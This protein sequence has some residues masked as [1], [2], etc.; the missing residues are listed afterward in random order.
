[1]K[2]I[3]TIH[4]GEFLVGDL[5]TRRFGKRLDVWVPA[6]D[7]GVDLLVTD[8][9]R[10]KPPVGLQVKFSRSYK[11]LPELAGHVRATSWFRLDP[12]KIKTSQADVWVFVI[13]T[14]KHEQHF[15]LIPTR[16]LAKRIPKG[17]GKRWDL[18]LWV[19]PSHKCYNMRGA[20]KQD[21]LAA[22]E[23]GVPDKAR[24]FTKWLESWD[25]L[26]SGKLPT[27]AKA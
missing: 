7:S 22:L 2:P 16:D 1:M 25:L 18:Y 6:K 14:L 3:F 17:V 26:E 13:I 24:D 15:V 8:K 4:E 23:A 11:F 19:Y 5:I 20:R 9:Q 10:K 12:T 21:R 27:G